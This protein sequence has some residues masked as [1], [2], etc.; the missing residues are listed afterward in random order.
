MTSTT[1]RQTRT[2]L[3]LAL[4]GVSAALS[5]APAATAAPVVYDDFNDNAT[6]WQRWS[7]GR[8]GGP[9]V[10]ETNQRFEIAFPPDS[11]GD[12]IAGVYYGTCA[13][14]GDYD[15]QVDYQLLDWPARNGVRMGLLMTAPPWTGNDLGVVRISFSY[16]LNFPGFPPEAYLI[17]EGGVLHMTPTGDTSGKLR[18]VRVGDV[19]TGYYYSGGAWV[20]IYSF[21]S[22]STND[23]YLLLQAW[24]HDWAFTD[25]PVRVA[26][27]NVIINQGQLICPSQPPTADAG[28]DQTVEGTSPAGAQVQLDGSGSSDPE[29]G[30]LIYAWDT[31]GDGQFDDAIG[32]T[33]TVQLGRGTHSVTLQV[34]DAD[35]WT[36]TDGVEIRVVDTTPPRLTLTVLQASL[37]PPN[38]KLTLVAEVRATDVCDPDPGIWVGVSSNEPINGPGDGNSAAD[39]V[40]VPNGGVWEVWVRSERAG[41]LRGREYYVD[42]LAWDA[43]GNVA[44]ESATITVGHSQGRR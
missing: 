32:A 39:W 30:D 29:G 38:H 13:F 7:P 12:F 41:N 31:D 24:S 10:A 3:V 11:S 19:A 9:T 44:V 34:T 36:S 18:A 25:Q 17:G 2:T 33:P 20:P 43:D 8:I 4:L 21:G 1:A 37:W 42:A 14:R 26:F 22:A 40:V 27:D 16:E 6:N 15:V 23:V 28:P 35:D 5:V